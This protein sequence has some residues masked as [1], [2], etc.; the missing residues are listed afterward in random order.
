MLLTPFDIKRLE[1]YANN[2]LDYHVVLD[3]LPTIATLFFDQRLSEDVH[4]SPVQSSILL[5]LGLQRKAIEDVSVRIARSLHYLP[6]I[7]GLM[8]LRLFCLSMCRPSFPS[9][10]TKPSPSSSKPSESSPLPSRPFSATPSLPPSPKSP[11]RT[12][13]ERSR[14]SARAAWRARAMWVRATGSR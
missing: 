7:F 3:L 11:P 13:F 6:G 5:A 2:T 10:S 12:S 8:V 9:L 1:S 14:R 4:L